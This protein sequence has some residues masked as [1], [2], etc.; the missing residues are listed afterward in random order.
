MSKKDRVKMLASMEKVRKATW[1]IYQAI[2][3]LDV[4]E[5]NLAIRHAREYRIANPHT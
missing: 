1:I 3:S 4:T 5:S 2:K